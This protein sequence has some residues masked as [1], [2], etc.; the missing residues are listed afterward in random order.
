ME[1]Q[2]I[3]I[4]G[5][6]TGLKPVVAKQNFKTIENQ[7]KKE[8]NIAVNPFNVLPFEEHYTWRDYM[9]ADIKALVEC[10]AIYMLPDYKDSKGAL[11]ELEI[12]KGLGMRIEYI[13]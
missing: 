13:N 4:S 1:K 6:I 9:K 7:I 10:D 12:A 3:Y 5:K 8:G 11:L 2:K